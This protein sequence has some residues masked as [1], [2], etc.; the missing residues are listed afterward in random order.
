MQ[1]GN[2][3]SVFAARLRQAREAAGMTQPQL[4]T[5][6][7][8]ESGIRLDPSAITRMER[9]NRMIRLNEAVHLSA[10]LGIKL[11]DL[12]VSKPPFFA[13]LDPR[14]Q[15]AQKRALAAEVSRLDARIAKVEA[16]AAEA[17]VRAAE[18]R[19]RREDLAIVLGMTLN[20]PQAEDG[21]D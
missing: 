16:D 15:E 18:L 5:R 10:I 12:V 20:A 6:L 3:E 4:A 17:Q 19:E 7:Y 9:G 1:E 2:P 13:G 11:W 21:E 8:E 14:D